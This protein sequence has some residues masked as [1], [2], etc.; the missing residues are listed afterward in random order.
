MLLKSCCKR[1]PPML[2]R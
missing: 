1:S 2:R